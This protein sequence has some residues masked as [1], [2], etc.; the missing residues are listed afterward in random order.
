EAGTC[1]RDNDGLSNSDENNTWHTDY[2]NPDTDGDGIKDGAEVSASTPSSPLNSCDPSQSAGYRGYDNSNALWQEA[3]CDG[4][5]YTNGT[6]DN[7]SLTPNN[8][9]SDP[10]DEDSACFSFT[11]KVYCEVYPTDGRTWLDR[12]LGSPSVCANYMDS[13]CY[14]AL[15][16]WGRGAD[17]HQKR[18]SI[19]TNANPDSFPYSSPFH[20][21]SSTGNFDWLSTAGGNVETSGFITERQASWS[22]LTINS[23]CPIGWYVPSIAEITALADAEGIVDSASAFISPLHFA[24]SGSRSTGSSNIEQA[25]VKGFIWTT[26][27][28]ST[29]NTSYAFTYTETETLWSRAYRATGYSVRCLKKQ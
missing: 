2:K 9:I 24:V 15:Y 25:N 14:G 19:A 22:S 6:E 4:D 28:S 16:Q 5:D 26:D 18:N 29:N 13:T 3:N 8:Y 12:D 10:Y 11:G 17:G 7:I 21:I 20:E 1:D 27:T 23:V